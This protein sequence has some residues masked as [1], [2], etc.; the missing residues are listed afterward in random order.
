MEIQE[1]TTCLFD[2]NKRYVMEYLKSRKLN[3]RE[4]SKIIQDYPFG[5]L[6]DT[7]FFIGN[8]EYS[9][10][11]FLSKSDVTGYDIKKVNVLLNTEALG[12]VAFAV[13]AGDDVLCFD[14]KSKGVFLWMVQTGGGNRLQVS[15]NLTEFLKTLN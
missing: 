2:Q 4:L 5:L 12:V 9:I 13:V 6:K 1:E 3:N 15:K 14:S 7:S 8:E 11:H 10:S